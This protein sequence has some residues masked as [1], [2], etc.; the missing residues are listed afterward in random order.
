[1]FRS[2]IFV[3]SNSSSPDDSV[4]RIALKRNMVPFSLSS[5]IWSGT[6]GLMYPSKVAISGTSTIIDLQDINLFLE[7]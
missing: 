7:D 6:K 2:S 1:M 3:I 5:I 4:N